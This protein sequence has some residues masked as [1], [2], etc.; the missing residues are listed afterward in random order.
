MQSHPAS[1][2]IIQAMRELSCK[3]TNETLRR[4]SQKRLNFADP[5]STT[6]EVKRQRETATNLRRPLNLYEKLVGENAKK[7]A[8]QFLRSISSLN[9]G[10]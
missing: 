8:P 5:F 6:T 1:T 2:R 9:F 4:L 3:S 10:I 7:I